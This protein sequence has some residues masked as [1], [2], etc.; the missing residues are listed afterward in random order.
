MVSF[1]ARSRFVIMVRVKGRAITVIRVR[2]GVSVRTVV[3][4]RD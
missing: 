3:S 2:F 4:V 1:N